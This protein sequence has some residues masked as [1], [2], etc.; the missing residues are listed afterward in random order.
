MTNYDHNKQITGNNHVALILHSDVFR[1]S[2]EPI[3]FRLSFDH[4]RNVDLTVC[5]DRSEKTQ[6][7]QTWKDLFRIYYADLGRYIEHYST[8]K[9]AWDDLK[10][11]LA[12]R[13]PRMIESLKG[14]V[15][16]SNA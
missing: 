4:A 14:T 7:G 12:E 6:K 10:M 16:K 2:L 15:E 13:C 8:L 1:D 9:K 11:Y 5:C 3:W